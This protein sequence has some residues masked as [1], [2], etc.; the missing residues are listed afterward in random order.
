M[1]HSVLLSYAVEKPGRKGEKAFQSQRKFSLL[2]QVKSVTFPFLVAVSSVYQLHSQ[3]GSP[4]FEFRSLWCM[5]WCIWGCH[6]MKISWFSSYNIGL[7]LEYI[8]KVFS[9][10]NCYIERTKLPFTTI[11]WNHFPQSKRILYIVMSS[12]PCFNVR[13]LTSGSQ[14]FLWTILASYIISKVCS[15]KG[16]EERKFLFCQVDA[17]G[18]WQP[19]K[20]QVTQLQGT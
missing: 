18:I 15:K 11:I 14:Q 20:S 3:E 4:S 9:L 8:F 5:T 2:R 6:L 17:M 16:A 12:K 1:P 19:Y 13:I 10:S 7:L